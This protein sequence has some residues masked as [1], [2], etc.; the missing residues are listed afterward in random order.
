MPGLPQ[1]ANERHQGRAAGTDSASIAGPPGS[2]PQRIVVIGYGF[3]KTV[4]GHVETTS[5]YHLVLS[6]ADMGPASEM[7]THAQGSA[8]QMRF[9][10]LSRAPRTITVQVCRC[11]LRGCQL[12][13][14]QSE[15]VVWQ[16]APCANELMYGD[17]GLRPSSALRVCGTQQ[18]LCPLHAKQ[19]LHERERQASCCC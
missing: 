13:Q 5:S 14:Q 7:E 18:H 11:K 16:K 15:Q 12:H 4:L 6:Q 17:S 8:L 2:P 9:P 10:P 3:L 19:P 1:S